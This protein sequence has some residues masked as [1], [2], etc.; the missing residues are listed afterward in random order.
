MAFTFTDVTLCAGGNH[1]TLH[2]EEDSVPRQVI[3][4]LSQLNH[5]QSIIDMIELLC[6]K[7]TQNVEPIYAAINAI[8]SNGSSTFQ[9][10]RA[11]ILALQPNINAKETV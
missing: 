9:A 10:K 5:E 7:D 2:I 11:T 6:G 1:V 4:D 3:M 8:R